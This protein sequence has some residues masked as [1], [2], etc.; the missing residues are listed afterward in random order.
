MGNTVTTPGAVGYKTNYAEI[1][2]IKD[3]DTTLNSGLF[4]ST[5][6][7]DMNTG[8]VYGLKANEA[9]Q[10]VVGSVTELLK[11]VLEKK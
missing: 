3:V 1:L 10:T 8:D 6:I 4:D 7:L 5:R 2:R 11:T 9:A